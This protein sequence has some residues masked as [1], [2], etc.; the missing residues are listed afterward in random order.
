MRAAKSPRGVPPNTS[1]QGDIHIS[2]AEGLYPLS[3]IPAVIRKYWDRA[4]KHPRGEPDKVVITAEAIKR[5]PR[6][7]PALPVSTV[8]SRTPEEGK[9]FAM[10]ILLSLGITAKAAREG[11]ATIRKGGMRGAAI[12]S[13]EKG[14]RLEPDR[15]RGVRVSRLG[16]APEAS[17]L[18]ASRL[19]RHRINTSPVK[20]ALVLASKVIAHGEVIADLCISDDPDYTTGYVAT[21]KFGY[22]RIPHLKERGCSAG[23]RVYFVREGCD[24]NALMVYLETT[25]VV[26]GTVSHCSGTRSPYEILNSPD[27]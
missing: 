16:I 7:I 18:L 9:A 15:R 27:R 22:V 5:K 10:D 24:V 6:R 8:I 17:K 21:K 1:H 20:E 4:L 26:I 23:G 3:A 2:G 12:I 14:I 11:Y 19:S 13:G 25:P